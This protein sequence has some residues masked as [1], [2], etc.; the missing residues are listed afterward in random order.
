MELF[1]EIFLT[2]KG[3]RLTDHLKRRVTRC[4]PLKSGYS[5]KSQNWRENL[6]AY[7]YMDFFT[8]EL[9]AANEN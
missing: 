6:R 4:M 8:E 7:R 9:V 2:A 1:N 3:S 5:T